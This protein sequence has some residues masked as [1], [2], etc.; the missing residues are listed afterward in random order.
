MNTTLSGATACNVEYPIAANLYSVVRR[1]SKH[2]QPFISEP[3]G[4]FTLPVL[5]MAKQEDNFKDGSSA[6]FL[7]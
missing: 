1:Y 7:S 2:S 5:N 3:L 4:E 6:L